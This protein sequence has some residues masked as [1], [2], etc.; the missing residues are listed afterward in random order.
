MTRSF[1]FRSHKKLTSVILIFCASLTAVVAGAP[2]AEAE[3]CNPAE[4]FCGFIHGHQ[5]SGSPAKPSASNTVRINP[6]AV[7][8]EKTLGIESI[9]YKGEADFGLIRG[10]GR[11]GAAISP[12]NSDETFFGPIGLELPESLA[13]RRL[14]KTK[15]PSQKLTLATS[16]NALKKGGGLTHSE[17]NIGV[18]AKYNELTNV[19]NP[20]GGVSGSLGPLSFGYALYNDQTQIDQSIIGNSTK[21]I[22]NSLV[23]TTSVGLYLGSLAVDYST[24]KLTTNTD[25][26]TVTVATASLIL[27]RGIATIANRNEQSTFG[28]YNFDTGL[29]DTLNHKN[30]YFGGLQVAVGSHV[31]VG[32]FY[33]YYLLRELSAA[34]F[35]FF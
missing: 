3:L 24:L 31:M 7:P 34:G 8:T 21:Y 32:A 26:A 13:N 19:L 18:L 29:V 33:N 17:I 11:I 23:Q 9:L 14:N 15:Y 4:E 20:G 16:F 30:E 27:K 6:A 2:I 22:L 5:S 10:L 12:S 35:F 28:R 1:W 25:S